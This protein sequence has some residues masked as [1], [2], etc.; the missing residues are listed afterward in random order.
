MPDR[1]RKR[2][3]SI[4]EFIITE[5][6]YVQSLQLIIEVSHRSAVVQRRPA[7]DILGRQVFFTTLQPVLAQRASQ[8]IFANIEDILM[9][10]TVRSSAGGIPL[11]RG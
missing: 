11:A 6:A 8:V 7:A 1:E 2:Q 3:E 5:Q 4:F 9:F 10:N